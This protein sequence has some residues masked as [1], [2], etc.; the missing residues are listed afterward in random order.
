MDKCSPAGLAIPVYRDVA[1]GGIQV[2]FNKVNPL[3]SMQAKH[4]LNQ[5]RQC[6]DNSA[7]NTM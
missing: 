3:A 5:G 1:V 2:L 6:N 7:L 4:C